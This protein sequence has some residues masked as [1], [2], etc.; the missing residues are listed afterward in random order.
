MAWSPDYFNTSDF[1]GVIEKVY[2]I[3]NIVEGKWDA[4]KGEVLPVA[5]AEH[6]VIILI[7]INRGG[8][9]ECEDVFQSHYMVKVTVSEENAIKSPFLFDKFC[10]INRIFLF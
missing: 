6:I 2:V 5:F 7:K 4:E 3:W 1:P 9:K 10:Y 8:R